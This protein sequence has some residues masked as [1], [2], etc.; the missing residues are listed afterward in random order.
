MSSIAGNPDDGHTLPMAITMTEPIPRMNIT[1]VDVHT[2]RR[3]N[4]D[5]GK[6]NI[7]ISGSSTR[8][9]TRI[10]K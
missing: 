4:D 2:G 6:A 7:H 10:R 5:A 1:D 3:G 9:L 8:R